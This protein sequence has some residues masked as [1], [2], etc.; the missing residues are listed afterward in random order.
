MRFVLYKQF[1]KPELEKQNVP[2]FKVMI[3]M[4]MFKDENRI[5]ILLPWQGTYIH[6]IFK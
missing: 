3:K 2:L 1:L 4:K 5:I 6:T